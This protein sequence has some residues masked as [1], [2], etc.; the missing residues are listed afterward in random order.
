M[1]ETF[2]KKNMLCWV[3]YPPN[4]D[5]NKKY[6]ALLYCQGGPQS[7]VS[8]FF[9]SRWNFFLM[10]S[11]GYIIIA[12]NR[13]GLPGFGREWL[14]E[15]SGDY[16]NCCMKDYLSAID[17][18]SKEKY[19][20][21]E[22]LGAIGASF[23]GYSVY[24][25]AGN[26]EKRFKTFIS[27]AGIF[28]IEQFY[29]ETEEMW[30]ANWDNEGAPWMNKEGNF[31][32]YLNSPHLYVDK[33]DTPILCIHGE[34]DYRILHSQ[35]ESAFHAARMKNIPSKLLIF[36]DEG[37]WIQKPQNSLIWQREFYSWLDK[38]LK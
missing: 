33:W 15:I 12:P 14:E 28:N 21:K 5:E 20:D 36:K 6:P 17:D 22:K 2:D 13:R 18:L 1:V 32:N 25:L 19:I 24:W 23:G 11:H 9:S 26:H 27:H 3:I 31:K 38:W 7:S 8:Q 37:H 16:Y 10:A 35:G 4:F 30:F 34:K 29:F